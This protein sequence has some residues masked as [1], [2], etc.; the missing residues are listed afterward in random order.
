M[1]YKLSAG[2]S[3]NSVLGYQIVPR[4]RFVA[5]ESYIVITYVCVDPIER[6]QGIASALIRQ[7][8]AIAQSIDHPV[9]LYPMPLRDQPMDVKALRKFYTSLG[10]KKS[11]AGYM[12]WEPQYIEQQRKAA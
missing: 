2:K 4:N 8:L 7:V 11:H 1:F 12:R 3:Y 10:F 9:V 5:H 6:R